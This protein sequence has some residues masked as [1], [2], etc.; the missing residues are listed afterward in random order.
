MEPSNFIEELPLKLPISTLTKDL[1][2]IQSSRYIQLVKHLIGAKSGIN[3]KLI[4]VTA[5]LLVPLMAAFALVVLCYFKKYG[6]DDLTLRHIVACLCLWILA[7]ILLIPSYTFDIAFHHVW[8]IT[9]VNE[10]MPA[11]YSAKCFALDYP[12]LFADFETFVG[13]IISMFAQ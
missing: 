8:K 2:E 9:A 12:P 10:P 7:K 13:Y 3:L 11:L 6:N 4:Y 5:A 1:A